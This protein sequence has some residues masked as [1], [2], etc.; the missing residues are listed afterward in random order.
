MKHKLIIL[1]TFL[2]SMIL[3]SGIA[4]ASTIYTFP[5]NYINW[6]GHDGLSFDENGTPNVGDMVVIVDDNGYLKSVAIEMEK[7]RV[8]DSLFI[9]SDYAANDNGTLSEDWESWKYFVRDATGQDLRGEGTIVTGLYSVID[10]ADDPYKY[11]YADYSGAR[12]G[13]P[14]G[15]ENDDLSMMVAGFLPTYSNNLLAYDFSILTGEDRIFIGNEFTIGYAPWCANDVTL[16]VT[17]PVPEP[18]TI[19]LFGTGL[20]GLAGIGRKKIFN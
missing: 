2:L 8:Y 11:I 20:M 19:F 16:G 9:N 5:D 7:R 6:P 3:C 10:S 18:A 15:I 14:S 1:A 4:G 12:I 13:H 17:A